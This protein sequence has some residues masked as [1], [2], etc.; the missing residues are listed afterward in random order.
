MPR[1]LFPAAALALFTL[2]TVHAQ[3]S[4]QPETR[5]LGQGRNY[6]RS[7]VISQGG[8]VA[9]SQVLASQ[10]GAQILARGG[11]VVDAAIAANAV[12]C[13]TEPLM[14]SIGGDLFAMY[15]DA[16]TGKLTGLNS[17][18]PAPKA[19][20]PEFLA[21]KGMK[22]MPNDGIHSVTV[23]G[24]VQG[25]YRIHQRFG[26]LPW[27]DLFQA[28]IAF[29]E[30]GF[31][32][33][34]GIAE[35]WNGG[36]VIR[37][38][39]ANDESARVFLPGGKAPKTGEVFRDPDVGHALRL[40][41]EQG[42][43]AFYKGDIAK[44]ILKTSQHLGGTITAED[45][46]SFAP[47]WVEPLSIDYRGWRVYELPPN[48]QGM[49]A[50]EM[51]N[52]ME[53]KPPSVLG[54]FSPVEIH[55]RIEA[56]K[57]AYSDIHRYDADPRTY[58]VPVAQLLSKQYAH[59]RAALIDPDRANCKVENGDPIGSNTTYLTVVDKDGNIASWIQSIFGSF[60]SRV[61]VEGMGFVLQNRGGGFTL[62]PHSPNVLAGGKRPFHTIIPAFMEKGD[63][64][65]G[66]GIMGGAV[67]PLAHAQFVS[68]F[69][70]YGMNL[71][72]A[73]EAP[74]FAKGNAYGCEVSIESRE[75]AQTLQQLSERGHV[76]QIRREYVE[77]FGRGQAI[78]HD[79]KT[80]TNF[81]A[82]DPRADGAAI[83]EPV[84][85]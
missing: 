31:P 3:E 61:T 80:G 41:A 34:E 48:G 19:L 32:V 58:D 66:F 74:R 8:I 84:R 5:T 85:P 82:S 9:T 59:K 56:M 37:G 30:Q 25:W 43:D 15:W 36:G 62:D 20:S 11:S 40:I 54:P 49:A 21:Q 73:L 68:N 6:G 18:G 23:P 60:G 16:K 1:I 26:K 55:K 81:A 57:L 50:L 77:A 14:T 65:V 17:S 24:V 7:M 71:Q 51:L 28:A 63:Q 69:V 42:P 10:A 78:L 46:A 67:Q 39:K 44:A 33:H 75:P 22:R 53:T 35:V 13:V 45:L 2:V 27:K 72:E 12:L 70:D 52:I 29:A 47:E 76:I 64:H 79:S 83:P 4:G 38:L